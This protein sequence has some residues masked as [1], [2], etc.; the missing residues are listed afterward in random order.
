MDQAVII[1]E[2]ESVLKGLRKIRKEVWG[3][4]SRDLK[5]LPIDEEIAVLEDII[6]QMTYKDQWNGSHPVGQS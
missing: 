5:L 3:D 1:K 2:L 6:G 4:P